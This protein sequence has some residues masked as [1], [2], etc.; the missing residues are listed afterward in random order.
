MKCRI[1]NNDAEFKFAHRVMN[2]YNVNYYCCPNCSFVFTEDP[3]WL[4]EA[5]KNPINIYDT[6]IISRNLYFS[7]V[8]SSVIFLLF[9]RNEKF[10]DYAGGYGILTRL[11]R[12]IGFD[13]YW[14]DKHTKNILAKGFGLKSVKQEK[15]EI[16]TTFEVFEHLTDPVKEIREML[17][18]SPNIIFSTE[19][20]P[21]PIP[22]PESWW[23]Y[24]FNHG[25]HVSFYS[26]RTLKVIAEKYS[27]NFYSSGVIHL[28][29]KKQLNPFIFYL[30]VKLAKYGLASAVSL[31]MKSKMWDD[32]FYLKNM[33]SNE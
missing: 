11:M 30:I 27:L 29:T 6:G 1:C 18:L 5:Y 23:Y 12:D 32:Y 15:F 24:E 21:L 17:E 10:L 28:F 3:Y 14:D 2:K 19:L 13:F 33:S 8:I 26:L 20:L 4:E 31:F 25:Q 7:K 9:D 22:D 16:L